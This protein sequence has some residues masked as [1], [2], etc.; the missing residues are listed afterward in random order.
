MLGAWGGKIPPASSLV[1][2]EVPQHVPKTI[3][4]DLSPICPHALCKLLGFF[5]VVVVCS[6][7]LVFFFFSLSFFFFFMLPLLWATVFLRAVT[8]VPLALPAHPVLNPL[9][10]KTA[11]SKYQWF[12]KFTEFNPSGF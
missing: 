2:K 5:F 7:G 4:T 12:Y 3:L 10:F 11:G 6:F 8:Q 9:A 1:F